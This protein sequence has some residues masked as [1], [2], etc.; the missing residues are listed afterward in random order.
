[1]LQAFIV[2]EKRDKEGT[3]KRG[4]RRRMEKRIKRLRG[5]RRCLVGKQ[6]G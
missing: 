1:V 2:R 5:G 4:R 3:E 6:S